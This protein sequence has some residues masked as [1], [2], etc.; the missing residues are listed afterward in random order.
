[1]LV[2]RS[3]ALAARGGDRAKLRA[4]TPWSD[5]AFKSFRST[6]HTRLTC[7]TH[8]AYPAYPACRANVSA[9]YS[10]VLTLHSWVRWIALVAGV[11]ATLA[12]LRGRVQGGSSVATQAK[13]PLLTCGL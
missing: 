7:Q 8:P 1:M 5:D 9:M 4:R 13:P 10:L 6:R 11:G 3:L 12:A 2:V